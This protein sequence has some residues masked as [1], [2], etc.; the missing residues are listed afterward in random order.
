MTQI[1]SKAQEPAKN[2]RRKSPRRDVQIW[3]EEKSGRST[4]FHLITNLSTS[5]FFIEKKIPFL[6]GS[7]LN[8]EL[9]LPHSQ[10]KLC[11]TGKVVNNYRDPESN[12]I[13][14]GVEFLETDE[15][16]LQAIINYLKKQ[17]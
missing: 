11:L 3:V 13:G 5:G 10:E 8:L 15:K 16:T 1:S 17:Q 7:V 9:T 4:S 14:T 12:A 6:I 2:D